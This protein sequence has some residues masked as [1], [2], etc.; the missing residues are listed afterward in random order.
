MTSSH[1]PRPD[2]SDEDGKK[3]DLVGAINIGISLTGDDEIN[4]RFKAC[5]KNDFPI[6]LDEAL[7]LIFGTSEKHSVNLIL[8]KARR[9]ESGNLQNLTTPQG[10]WELYKRVIQEFQN[11]LGETKCKVIETESANKMRLI[12]CQKCPLYEFELQRLQK[13]YK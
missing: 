13:R 9:T 8:Q 10:I 7:Q 3:K 12:H 6:C 4:K 11:E 2:S 5:I 1:S